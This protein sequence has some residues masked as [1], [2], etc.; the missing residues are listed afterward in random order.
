MKLPVVQ[1]HPRAA[2]PVLHPRT[3]QHNT[4]SDTDR[5]Y[6]NVLNAS[7]GRDARI[8][9]IHILNLEEITWQHST[10]LMPT[11][12]VLDGE[13]EDLSTIHLPSPNSARNQQ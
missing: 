9:Q 10:I 7:S 12:K 2:T 5:T 4:D 6:L 8:F 11:G 13:T 3:V 1:E